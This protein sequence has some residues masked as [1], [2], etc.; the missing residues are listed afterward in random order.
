MGCSGD[1]TPTCT[2][3]TQDVGVT[4]L[5][6]CTPGEVRLV[7]GGSSTQG[8]LEVC[9]GGLWGT[10]C[11]DQFDNVDAQVVCKQ[12]GLPYAGAEA[13]HNAEFGQ[14]D[15]HIALTN[16]YCSGSETQLLS[17]IFNTGS[18]VTCNHANDAGVICQDLC[19]NGAIRVADGDTPNMGRVE[20]CYNGEWGTICDKGWNTPDVEVACYQLGFESNSSSKL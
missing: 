9:L 17:C 13:K 12:L 6:S 14:G 8:R 15:D 19:T 18:A 10:V 11:D 16:L 3:H 4:C 5:E 1:M 20:V 7:D 2:S